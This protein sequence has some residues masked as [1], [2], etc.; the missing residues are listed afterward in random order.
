MLIEF[1]KDI[2][3]KNLSNIQACLAVACTVGEPNINVAT[4]FCSLL[5]IGYDIFFSFLK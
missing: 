5:K 2:L 1:A 4:L 3:P